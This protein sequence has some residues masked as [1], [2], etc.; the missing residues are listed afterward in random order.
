MNCSRRAAIAV[1]V[2][3]SAVGLAVPGVGTAAAPSWPGLLANGLNTDDTL[4]PF[5]TGTN[6]TGAHI[7]LNGIQVG[8]VAI[9]PDGHT[10]WT[11]D[12]RAQNSTD[13]LIPVDLTA[14]PP[15]AGAAVTVSGASTGHLCQ[16]GL[17]DITAGLGAPAIAP[18]GKTLYVADGATD[19]VYPVAISGESATPET[20]ISLPPGSEPTAVAVSADG[21]ELLVADA[22]TDEVSVIATATGSLLP[23]IEL[24]AGAH[25]NA[26]AVTPDSRSAYVSE[27]GLNQVVPINLSANQA[28]SPIAVGSGPNGLAITPDG[29]RLYITGGGS[30]FTAG[31]GGN[32]APGQ[33]GSNSV[34]VISTATGAVLGTISGL[35]AEP[36]AP[37]MTPDGT[38]L[39]VPP[40]GSN[41]A[42]SEVT[43][44]DTSMDTAGT[45][46]AADPSTF[47]AVVSPDQPPV[48]NFTVTAA[49][50]GQPTSFD[51]SSSVLALGSTD[52]IVSYAWNFG[53]G[54]AVTVTSSPTITHTYGADGT[55]TATLTE[56][57]GAGTSTSRVFTGQTMLRNGSS[58]ARDA[59]TV[60]ITPVGP[61]AVKVQ[62]GSL[63]YG[64][65]APGHTSPPLPITVTNVG[66]GPLFVSSVQVVG[67][68]PSDFVLTQDGCASATVASGAT[69]TALVAFKPTGAGPRRAVLEFVDNASG[70][71]HTALLQ[72]V[73]ATSATLIGTVRGATG[74]PVAGASV[75]VCTY[76][77]RTVCQTTS[78][79]RAGRFTVRSLRAASYLLE[80]LP[81]RGELFGES[82][83]VALAAGT[84]VARTFHLRP[85]QGPP[86]GFAFN[87]ATNAGPTRSPSNSPVDLGAPL[88]VLPDG[89]PNSFAGTVI[90]Y[91]A[92]PSGPGS[93]TASLG[94]VTVI[95]WYD[96]SGRPRFV[97]E[98]PGNFLAGWAPA[99]NG[100]LGQWRVAL[101]GT[102]TVGETNLRGAM[103]DGVL[104]PPANGPSFHGS[105]RY[106]VSQYTFGFLPV[107]GASRDRY[108]TAR[109]S[110]G[111]PLPPGPGSPGGPALTYAP[112]TT[113]C[114]AF[115][116]GTP[117]T[118]P[119]LLYHDQQ[120]HVFPNGTRVD[121]TDP[122]EPWYVD[123]Q[124]HGYPQD[125][126]WGMRDPSNPSGPPDSIFAR[127]DGTGF[128]VDQSGDTHDVAQ[129]N[130]S[131]PSSGIEYLHLSASPAATTGGEGGYGAPLNVP[132]APPSSTVESAPQFTQAGW[133]NVPG[134]VAKDTSAPGRSSSAG[135]LARAGAGC[136]NAP[137][138]APAPF[139][140][141]VSPSGVVITTHG[142]PLANAK[143]TLLRSPRRSGTPLQLPGGSAFMSPADRRNPDYTNVF[144]QF[145]WD[146][147]PGDYEVRATH[148]GCTAAG[149]RTDQAQSPLFAVPPPVGNLRLVL[150]CPGLHRAGIA[151]GVKVSE[152]PVNQVILTA[153][154][155]PRG[156]RVQP[157][158]LV[159]FSI[160][161]RRVAEVP[162]VHR[163]GVAMATVP[164]P[165]R[166]TRIHAAYL[167][168]S[169]HEAI[170][171]S[172]PAP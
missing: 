63:D 23:A 100:T 108:A 88:T 146:L 39:Y 35:A 131:D 47:Q 113:A 67:D 133:Q 172:L 5:Q 144:G 66:D 155:K 161:G 130:P 49:Q 139:D 61:S 72:G 15:L 103:L 109:A 16:N 78:S 50:A 60:V 118:N 90:T 76:P 140:D 149:G 121:R 159:V 80:I 62:G 21:S 19:A 6:A 32:C 42:S 168:D 134:A 104:T 37:G 36:S 170:G 56:T 169:V 164:R 79:D 117:A 1:G 59:K 55:Y 98:V 14:S 75:S 115:G 38:A 81:G 119:Q 85:P 84:T 31:A 82:E 20:P 102:P 13:D 145:G 40:G 165:R 157:L 29:A 30:G 48:A 166:G 96:A 114:P 143:V 44:I 12:V 122:Y 163:D 136:D 54:S 91:Y 160:G 120:M 87:G 105:A 158:G 151:I 147:L 17:Q 58:S 27:G 106:Q 71:P 68:S 110:Q 34:S 46:F 57:D 70:S 148:P 101:S 124:G 129:P 132:D 24:A 141:Y 138:P 142:V 162:I 26:I 135:P 126:N 7:A 18:D 45:P 4:T 51:A 111:T 128:T 89:P 33:P 2:I 25:P 10:A 65:L 11:T 171:V 150:S 22:G 123:A 53:D 74:G 83:V 8:G 112:T 73:G 93:A 69:C 156:G 154:V 95:Y 64:T 152:V 167:G 3:V 153:T 9:T 137:A 92:A 41:G 107:A 127:P 86:P 116:A 43:A 99:S 77:A 94:S 125:P 28:G 52:P 97:E